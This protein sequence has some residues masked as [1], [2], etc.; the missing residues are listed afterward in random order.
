MSN[1]ALAE[2]LFRQAHAICTTDPQV[3]NELGVV[4]FRNHQYKEAEQWLNKALDRLPDQIKPGAQTS[5]TPSCF[6]LAIMFQIWPISGALP[7]VSRRGVRAGMPQLH[8]KPSA[9]R[10]ELTAK[11][12]SPMTCSPHVVRD[13]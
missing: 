2:Q 3:C 10:K 4:C 13:I 6:Y 12:F 1:L 5:Y 9:I 11:S 8:P 7:E